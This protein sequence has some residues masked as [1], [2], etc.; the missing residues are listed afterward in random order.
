M[1]EPGTQFLH[2]GTFG[3]SSRWVTILRAKNVSRIVRSDTYTEDDLKKD[4]KHLARRIPLEDVVNRFD[5]IE[6]R[7]KESLKDYQEL[8]AE[9]KD[10]MVAEIIEQLKEAPTPFEKLDSI[11]GYFGQGKNKRDRMRQFYLELGYLGIEDPE[12]VID[13]NG[14][15]AVHFDPRNL[16]IVKRYKLEDAFDPEE[17]DREEEEFW[18]AHAIKKFGENLPSDFDPNN[19]GNDPNNQGDVDPPYEKGFYYDFDGV[20]KPDPR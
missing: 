10:E 17:R 1:I 14:W 7:R 13:T 9:D 11:S 8:P 18:K 6:S 19:H 3:S 20:R 4:V 15:T 12:G 5:A 16:Q 2:D